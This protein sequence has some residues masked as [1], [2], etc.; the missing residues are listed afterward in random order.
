M[1]GDDREKFLDELL[2]SALAHYGDAQPRPGLE[3]RVLAGLRARP[4]HV[5]FGWRLMTAGGMAAAAAL[6]IF[7]IVIPKHQGERTNTVQTPVKTVPQVASN[8]DIQVLK[9]RRLP[10]PMDRTPAGFNRSRNAVAPHVR[11]QIARAVPASVTTVPRQ[12]VFPSPTPLSRQEQLL[13]Q[14]AQQAKPEELQALAT[15]TSAPL[16][17]IEVRPLDVPPLAEGPNQ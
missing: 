14:L 6:A 4:A 5:S 10:Q 13:L 17:P 7:L 16:Q 1:H 15:R 8:S 9:S 2:D 3:K 12:A 11:P